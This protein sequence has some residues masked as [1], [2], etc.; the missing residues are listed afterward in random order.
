MLVLCALCAA[1]AV[2]QVETAPAPELGPAPIAP[3]R[4]KLSDA[5]RYRGAAPAAAAG[6]ID[7]SNRETVRSLYKNVLEATT[8]VPMGWTGAITGCVVGGT[9]Q[10]YKDA[11]LQRINWFRGMAGV[12]AGVTLDGALGAKDSDAAL[13]ISANQELSHFPPPSWQCYTAAGADASGHSNICIW[14]GAFDDPGCVEL[15]IRDHGVNNDVVGHRRWLL[16][17]STTVMATGDVR[18]S[19]S[20]GATYPTANAIWVLPS[21]YPPRP[22]TRDD[23]VAWPPKGYVPYQVVPPRWSIS[24]PS[25]NF[26]GAN[27]TMTRGGSSIPLVLEPIENGYG[28]NTLVWVANN[29]DP[30]NFQ[31]NWARPTGDETVHVTVANATV[32]GS[33]RTFTYDVVIFDPD[34]GNSCGYTLVPPSPVSASASGLSGVG[35]LVQTTAGCAWT[36]TSP[37]SWVTIT[38]GASGSGPGS[39][40]F[41]IAA[42]PGPGTRSTTITVAG[43]PYTINQAAPIAPPPNTAPEVPSFSPTSGSGLTTSFQVV[44]RDANGFA[45]LAVVNLLINSALDGRNACYAAYT[46]ADNMLYLVN[47]QGSALLPGMLLNGSGSISNSACTISG[48]GSSATPS[49]LTLS[50]T[51]KVTFNQLSFSGDKVVYAAARDVA[52]A[53][54]GWRTK[55][56]W[57][58]PQA[59]GV[60]TVA[61]VAPASG[62]VTQAQLTAVFRHSTSGASI[63]N[64]QLLINADLNANGACYAGFVAA[65]SQLFLVKDSGPSAGLIGPLTAGGSIANSQCRVSALS[66]SVSGTD[67]TVNMTVE[68]LGTFKGPK[69]V[70]TAAQRIVGSGVAENTGWRPMSLWTIP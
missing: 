26:S 42:N 27:V 21:S 8:G 62:T 20:S 44:A 9:T 55:G 64:A 22:A 48:A 7:T 38:A 28:E 68:F 35:V 23:F 41:N 32:G 1:S 5:Q 34:G 12:P 39:V 13:M 33:P 2:S 53:S 60:F 40:S 3:D 63:T 70:Y 51:L 36:A 52:N 4:G 43:Q 56:V 65:G 10:T 31:S 6:W 61:S 14:Y 15:Y 29:L 46:R 24:Y 66:S 37:V 30:D 19:V 49:G 18:Q 58:V 25:A 54:T 11:V 50:L 59:A 69:L 45:D 67:L 17:P 57:R 47:D 16:F